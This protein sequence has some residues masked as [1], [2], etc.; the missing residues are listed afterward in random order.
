MNVFNLSSKP[1]SQTQLD[2]LNNGLSF[3]PTSHI[4]DFEIKTDLFRFFRTIKL[5][6]FF[7]RQ[8]SSLGTQKTTPSQLETSNVHDTTPVREETP[9]RSKS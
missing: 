7:G 2:V 4:N 3:V 8:D 1:L 9:F 6:E 5:R